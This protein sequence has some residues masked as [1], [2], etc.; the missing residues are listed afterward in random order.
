MIHFFHNN[1][2]LIYI[3]DPMIVSNT[4]SGCIGPQ[5][6]L[7]LIALSKPSSCAWWSFFFFWKV[8]WCPLHHAAAQGNV[9]L[10]NMLLKF[11]ANI[12][13]IDQVRIRNIL[14]KILIVTYPW[15]TWQLS[16]CENI[17]Y[18]GCQ[19]NFNLQ[20]YNFTNLYGVILLSMWHKLQSNTI[21]NIYL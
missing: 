2:I 11:G 8:G 14:E 19:I 6:Y 4:V 9:Y 20:K 7:I 17:Q 15:F 10:I 18:H 16:V 21:V 5:R 12:N 3:S 13:S 1:K